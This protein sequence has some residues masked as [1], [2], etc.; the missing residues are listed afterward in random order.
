MRKK[1]LI[2]INRSA[3]ITRNKDNAY[4]I[5][6]EFALAG[7]EPIVY[8][9][10][11]ETELDSERILAGY[12]GEVDMVICAGGDGTLNHVVNGVLR[13]KK[14]VR[15]GY[16][17]SGSTNDFAK[18]FGIPSDTHKACKN[19]ISGRPMSYD[20]GKIGD[21]YFNYVAAFGAF[22]AISYSTNQKFKNELG[23]AAYVLNAIGELPAQ[24]SY[25]SHLKI[26]YDDIEEEG[27]Y[28]FGAL[29]NSTSIGGTSLLNKAEIFLDDGEME[30][31]LIKAPANITELP[32]IIDCLMRKDLNNEYITFAKIKEVHF[33][34]DKEVE[35]TIDGEY[36]GAFN[37]LDITVVRRAATIMVPLIGKRRSN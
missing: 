3:G 31:L 36:G 13:M 11:P 15:I 20:V 37:N 33:A 32:L 16:I 30:L 34:S 35:W 26:R 7:F 24:M 19:A 8:P 9:I 14:P 4:V 5:V 10:V 12:D 1:V 22:S 25:S 17:P 29:C 23:H 28:L 21:R 2:L 27:N 6:Q 18:G